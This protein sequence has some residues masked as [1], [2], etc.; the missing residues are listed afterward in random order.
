[1]FREF[2]PTR[3]SF[4]KTAT[5]VS[6]VLAI[7]ALLPSETNA[8]EAPK[9][10]EGY[11]KSAGL[12]LKVVNPQG[13]NAKENTLFWVGPK[14]KELLLTRDETQ[15]TDQILGKVNG[16]DKLLVQ[17]GSGQEHVYYVVGSTGETY[18]EG[19]GEL[20]RKFNGNASTRRPVRYCGIPTEAPAIPMS[21]RRFLGKDEQGNNIWANDAADEGAIV[22]E[23]CGDK[24]WTVTL[25]DESMP[26]PQPALPAPTPEQPKPAPVRPAPAQLPK[27]GDG[28]CSNVIEARKRGEDVTNMQCQGSQQ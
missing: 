27:A 7:D 8:C 21:I 19:T 12:R 9:F 10:P 2:E 24:L 11:I 1:M 15:G 13:Q 22:P 26:V 25:K 4:L 14:E 20:Y 5:V 28:S 23:I 17:R 18:V 16:T 6:T 3:R